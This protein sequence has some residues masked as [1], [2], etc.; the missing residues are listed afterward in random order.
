M[1][2]RYYLSDIVGDGSIDNPYRPAI[3]DEGVNHV[4]VFPPQNPDGT[5]TRTTCLVLVNSPNH[6]RFRGRKDIDP[7][8]DFPLDGKVS[9]VE[10]R[11]RMD[12]G[13]A[14]ERR[15][16]V[17]SHLTGK[18]GYREVIRSIGKELD[19]NFDENNFDVSE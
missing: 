8:P 15:G 1:A 4:A 16:F 2:K 18:D 7:L 17:S 5:Y 9:A 12:A 6:G 10:G 19:G 11:S 13:S 14:L 3:A